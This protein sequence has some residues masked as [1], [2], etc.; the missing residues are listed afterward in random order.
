[1]YIAF[2]FGMFQVVMNFSFQTF[3]SPLSVRG[4]LLYVECVI[5]LRVV[6]VKNGLNKPISELGPS[7]SVN[8]G[9]S[10]VWMLFEKILQC[11]RHS[12]SLL[13][14]QLVEPCHFT[15]GIYDHKYE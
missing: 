14:F 5:N 12:C 4:M 15:E 10:R 2:P 8:D 1:M 13:V 3:N 11:S 7:V 6:F 9:T